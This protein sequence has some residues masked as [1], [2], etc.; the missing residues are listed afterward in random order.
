[1]IAD[2]GRS[3]VGGIT[4]DSGSAAVARPVVHNNT[5]SKPIRFLDEAVSG[6]GVVT[7]LKLHSFQAPSSDSIAQFPGADE[8]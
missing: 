8:K 2:V 1:M 5:S 4:Q 7:E 3:S 6:L